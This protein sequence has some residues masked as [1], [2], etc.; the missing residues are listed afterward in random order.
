MSPPASRHFVVTEA[1]DEVVVE[2]A[3]GLHESV[4][5]GGAAEGEAFFLQVF[6]NALRQRRFRRHLFDARKTVLLRAAVEIFPEIV[7]EAFALLDFQIGARAR[8]RALDLH[9]VAHDAFVLHQA[10]DLLGREAHDLLGLEPG[11]R[12]PE[13][14]ALAQDGDPGE[15]GLET[16]EQQLFEERARVALRHAPF[17]VV[18]GDVKGIE[19]R[20]A[21]A[22][23]AVGMDDEVAC[24]NFGFRG[25]GMIPIK[26]E[27]CLIPP[28]PE[29]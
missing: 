16:V 6:R 19:T 12:L 4:D 20:P 17:L 9:A 22:R 18:V 28:R 2:E 27:R 26:P 5:D 1:A 8:D 10:F 14:V 13:I 21:A 24:G 29:T 3:R 25:H 11:E 15:A 23:P 7:G